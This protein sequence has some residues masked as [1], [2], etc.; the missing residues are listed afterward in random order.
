MVGSQPAER[1]FID[2]DAAL[3]SSSSSPRRGRQASPGTCIL[4]DLGALAIYPEH[5]NDG[6]WGS[7]PRNQLTPLSWQM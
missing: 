3:K 4:V 2:P 1:T 7:A 5:E 6:T